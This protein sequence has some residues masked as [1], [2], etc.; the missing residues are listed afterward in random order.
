MVVGVE[1]GV[2][3]TPT[4]GTLEA[5]FLPNNLQ[6]PSKAPSPLGSPRPPKAP[7]QMVLKT[8]QGM[9]TKTTVCRQHI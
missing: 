5:F 2:A 3:A 8:F 1:A 4:V 9:P 7:P 6:L